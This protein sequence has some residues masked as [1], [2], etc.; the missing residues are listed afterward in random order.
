MSEHFAQHP[1]PSSFVPYFWCTSSLLCSV[2]TIYFT[3]SFSC[4]AIIPRP[5]VA[6]NA[7]PEP[8][9][10]V[11]EY[12]HYW[13]RVMNGT[14]AIK[15]AIS[16]SVVSETLISISLSF[17]TGV[18]DENPS[19]N[20]YL[21]P[22]GPSV[23]TYFFQ[24]PCALSGILVNWVSP[25]HFPK[26]F[27]VCVCHTWLLIFFWIRFLFCSNVPYVF[28]LWLKDCKCFRRYGPASIIESRSSWYTCSH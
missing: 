17:M 25:V 9:F 4:S 22:L 13:Q 27:M 3:T 16:N 11:W 15:R 26:R 24:F 1:S 7:P 18:R 19:L 5:E 28:P 12:I 8:F 10:G 23:C 6:Q 2:F 21:D 20:L 14:S